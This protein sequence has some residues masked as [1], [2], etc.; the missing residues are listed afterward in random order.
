MWISS[1]FYFYNH[2]RPYLRESRLLFP[3][4]S[5]IRDLGLW[6]IGTICQIPRQCPYLCHTLRHIQ[7]ILYSDILTLQIPLWSIVPIAPNVTS[8][9]TRTYTHTLTTP[10]DSD[11]L[12]GSYS[13]SYYPQVSPILHANFTQY[14][15]FHLLAKRTTLNLPQRWRFTCSVSVWSSRLN[16]RSPLA[17]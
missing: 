2:N 6:W 17:F 1:N 8:S 10:C 7:K 4:K 11:T 14:E 5:K 9:L 16:V 15:T 13:L 12:L 3:T